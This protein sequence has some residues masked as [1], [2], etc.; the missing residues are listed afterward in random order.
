MVQKIQGHHEDDTEYFECVPDL[1]RLLHLLSSIVL[2]PILSPLYRVPYRL[3]KLLQLTVDGYWS[4]GDSPQ[5]RVDGAVEGLH[6]PEGNAAECRLPAADEVGEMPQGLRHD[7]S[8]E[9]EWRREPLVDR[10]IQ[11]LIQHANPQQLILCSLCLL[12]GR[13]RRRHDGDEQ[14]EEYDGGED[15]VCEQQ[16]GP[17][18]VVALD[19]VVQRLVELAKTPVE[20]N[21][22]QP[23]NSMLIDWRSL[24]VCRCHRVQCEHG[25]GEG[26]EVLVVFV[27][28]EEGEDDREDQQ[29]VD[30]QTQKHADVRKHPHNRKYEWPHG[31]LQAG[32]LQEAQRKEQRYDDP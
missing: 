32:G 23:A 12:D 20:T 7:H 8:D 5:E 26:A 27:G 30:V 9:V 21:A 2:R 31:W 4:E 22:M 28:R 25:F 29:D 17:Q 16:D 15:D 19:G 11:V 1:D 6:R 24:S 14:V 10:H 13:I 18:R 3:L